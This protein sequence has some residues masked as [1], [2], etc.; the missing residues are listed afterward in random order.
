MDRRTVALAQL[1][2]VWGDRERTVAKAADAVREAARGGASIV[3]FGESFVPGYP[4]WLARGDGA[5]FEND[6]LKDMH[7]Y[8]ASAC[9]TVGAGHLDPIA[10][11][12]REASVA[13]V[14][15]VTERPAERGGH[16]LYASRVMIDE[17]GRVLPVHR[18]L[19]PT[20]EERLVWGVGDGHG[21]RAHELAGVRV[22]ALNCWENWIPTA[23]AALH[24]QGVDLHVAIWPGSVGLTKDSTRFF[25]YEGRM[26]CASASALLRAQDVPAGVPMRERVIA[27]A[28]ETLQ[29]GGSAIAKPDGTWLVEPVA[30]DEGLMYA[31]IDANEVRRARQSFDYS[32]HYGRPEVLKLT[33]DRS[34]R[35]VGFADGEGR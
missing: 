16:S 13:V 5:R 30:G 4:F 23:R 25:A 3:C 29:D 24:A 11:A 1:A 26:F 12:A 18:K 6:E 19:V 10:Q 34:R 28:E 8:F 31:E 7:A 14:L 33:V 35:G 27:D 20:H 9:V 21:L 32:G 17:R 22:S 2:P 15:G